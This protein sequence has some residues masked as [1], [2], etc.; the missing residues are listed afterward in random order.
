MQHGKLNAYD[1]RQL[2]KH[3]QNYLTRD[4]ELVAAIFAL[5]IWRHYLYVCHVNIFTDHKSLQCIFKQKIVEFKAM[6][7]LDTGNRGITFLNTAKSLLVAE[8]KVRQFEDLALVKIRGSIPFQ[9]KQGF[10]L[11]KD[12]A[13]R[14]KDQLCVPNFEGLREKIMTEINQSR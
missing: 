14:Y 7:L 13:L 3:E 2:R 5:K 4:L 9:K 11:S 8:V 1:S 10:G 6:N 12:G